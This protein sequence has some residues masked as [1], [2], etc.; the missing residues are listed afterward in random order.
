M[1]LQTP[2]NKIILN[3]L[4]ADTLTIAAGVVTIEGLPSFESANV[5]AGECFRTCPSACVKQVVLITPTLPSATCECPWQWEL[6]LRTKRCADRQAHPQDLF[7]NPKQYLYGNPNATLTVTDI[8]ENIASFI[9]QDFTSPVVATL[10]GTPGSYTAIILEEKDCDGRNATCGYEVNVNAGTIAYTGATGGTPTP[11]VAHTSAV[12]SP[13]QIKRAN[14]ILPHHIMTDSDLAHCSTYCVYQFK[15]K[16][17]SEV[18]HTHLHDVSV[19]RYQT[20]EIWVDNTL[21]NLIA[22]WDTPLIAEL[23]CFG[24]ALV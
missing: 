15:V 23:P 18:N 13:S 24:A 9:N 19:E 1:S 12:L 3:T 11:A 21:A 6:I 17:M 4:T 22:D 8:C 10:V 16:P 2:N 7:G 14:P 20:F 5:V